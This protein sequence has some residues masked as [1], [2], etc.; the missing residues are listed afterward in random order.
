MLGVL[1]LGKLGSEV[2]SVGKAFHMDVIAWSENLTPEHASSL[3]AIRV[4]KDE[5]FQRADFVTIHLVLSKR[6]RGLLTA[7]ASLR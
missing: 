1:G 4:E 2:A 5:L 7:R 6:T 3:G